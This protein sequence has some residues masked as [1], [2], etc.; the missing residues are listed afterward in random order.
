MSTKKKILIFAL[1][2]LLVGLVFFGIQFYRYNSYKNEEDKIRIQI[3]DIYTLQVPGVEIK[4]IKITNQT[5]KAYK[6][7]IIDA[8]CGNWN[9]GKMEIEDLQPNDVIV[10]TI[11]ISK[12]DS[13]AWYCI[14]DYEVEEY[15]FWEWI[16]L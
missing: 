10:D 1:I 6:R 5:D 2:I 13:Y 7:V 8:K 12:I 4:G 15:K 3:Y 11:R 16:F 14:A 9:W